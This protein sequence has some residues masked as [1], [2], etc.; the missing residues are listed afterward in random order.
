MATTIVTKNGSGAPTA[1]DLVA[2]ELAVD[3]TNGRLYTENSGGTVLELGLNP[4][5]NVN[6]T[7]SVTADGLTVTGA[8]NAL[9]ASIGTAAQRVYI[10][11]NGTEINYNA[12]GNSNGSHMFQTG[13]IDRLN[14]ASNGDISFYEDTGTTPKFFWDASAESL[15]IGTSLPAALIHGMSGDLF[16]TANSTAADSGQGV[17]F[18][19]TTSG[20]ATSAAHAAIYGKRTDASNG[21]LRFDTR[22]SGTTQEAMRIDSAGNVDLYQ[23]NNLTWRFA[24]GSTIR[25][26]I[27]VDSA[28]NITFSNTS[29]NTERLR[30][31]A[32]GS[33]STPTLG[34]S[35]VRFGSGAGSSITAGGNDNTL[36]GDLAGDAITTGVSNTAAGK[37]ALGATTT[38]GNNAAL[39][40][41]ALI[42][43]TIGSY[44]TATG[45]GALTSNTT[46]SNNTA[47]GYNA[48][49][50]VTTGQYNTLIGGLAGDGATTASY[51]TAVGYGA[52]GGAMTGEGNVALGVNTLLAATS[53]HSNTAVGTSAMSSAT[54]GTNNVAV[55]RNALDSNTTASNNTAVGY[56]S[57]GANTTGTNNVAVGNAAGSLITT[58]VENTILGSG[59]GSITTGNQ[60]IAIG[61]LPMGG[62]ITTG[63]L[64]TTVGFA[65][66]FELTSGGNNTAIGYNAGRSTSPSGSITTQSDVIVLGNNNVSAAY[67]KVAWTVTSDARDKTDF[68]PLDLGL[69]FVK[70]LKPITYKW[71]MRSKY[72]N[73]EDAD[74]DLNA[75]TPDGTHKEDWLDVGFKAQDVE[76]LEIAAGYDKTNKTNLISSHTEDG[77]Q[78][79]LKYEKFVPILVKAIQDQQAIIDSLTARIEALES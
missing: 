77:K 70:K 58:G 11:P 23:G 28:D 17:F 37:D 53:A 63:S 4:S 41:N 16:L 59:A 36:I 54:T 33:I 76:A 64:N 10:T 69:D 56:D 40:K 12:S 60:N 39:G 57:L 34:T 5:G 42:S 43:N 45:K 29:S 25:G 61:Y 9:A 27:S 2:G 66:L 19:S 35:N 1:S 7:G 38:G 3:L 6:V 24:A 73:V 50:A 8:D 46:A 74:Y 13:N 68:T 79:G 21:Y 26:S 51:S 31:A 62:A 65:G 49:A 52:L 30:I 47:V 71:D 48:G 14:I 15:G 67:I 20:W 18:Q 55:G 32:D 44:N 22:Q 75:Q 78:M 72:G